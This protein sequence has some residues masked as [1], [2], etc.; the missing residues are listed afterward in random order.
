MLPL[1]VER[2]V[3]RGRRCLAAGVG[4]GWAA[5]WGPV[6]DV[7][8]AGA[9]VPGFRGRGAACQPVAALQ[10]PPWWVRPS[11]ARRARLTAPASSEKSASTLLWPRT[12]ARRAP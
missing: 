11:A 2:R 3:W 5:D 1:A 7:R 8:G 12:R 10:A 9:P 6:A 4:L